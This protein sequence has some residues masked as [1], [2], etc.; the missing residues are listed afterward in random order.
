MG[1]YVELGPRTID[2]TGQRFGMVTVLGPI[3]KRVTGLI[4]KDRHIAIIWECRCDCGQICQKWGTYL[5][6][7]EH[8]RLPSCGCAPHPPRK[9]YKRRQKGIDFSKLAEPKTLPPLKRPNEI[10]SL[11]RGAKKIETVWDGVTYLPVSDRAI[12]L[13]GQTKGRLKVLGLARIVKI[14]ATR[15]LYWHCRCACGTFTEKMADGLL[16][17]TTVSCGCFNWEKSTVH[18]H[19]ANPN[20]IASLLRAKLARD[21]GKEIPAP[22]ADAKDTG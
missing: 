6:H 9:P 8:K 4:A 11:K 20:S 7:A 17:G 13:T 3:E 19:K 12:D 15:R 5:Q 16:K 22:D 18:G 10:G 21:Y 14:G 2:L 1:K